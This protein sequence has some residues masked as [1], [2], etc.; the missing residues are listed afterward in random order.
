MRAPAGIPLATRIFLVEAAV[1]LVLGN[2]FTGPPLHDQ[3]YYLSLGASFAEG[4]GIGQPGHPTAFVPPGYPV[5][6]GLFLE[7]FGRHAITAIRVFQLLLLAGTA[8][9]CQD[10]LGRLGFGGR[11]RVLAQLGVAFYPPFVRYATFILTDTI[12]AFLIVGLFWTVVRVLAEPGVPAR[13]RILPWL[14]LAALLAFASVAMRP[15]GMFLTASL[16]LAGAGVALLRPPA[17]RRWALVALAVV[18][19]SLAF[20]TV[21][22]LRN[23]RVL[24]AFVPFSTSGGWVAYSGNFVAG[25]GDFGRADFAKLVGEAEYNRVMGLD[26]IAQN[27]EFT[28]RFLDDLKANPSAM[29]GLWAKKLARYWLNLGYPKPPSRG[30]LFLAAANLVLL[31]LGSWGAWQ[32]WRRPVVPLVKWW[33]LWVALFLVVMTATHVALL[34]VVRY[35]YPALVFVILLAAI[36]ADRLVSRQSRRGA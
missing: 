31:A 13:S 17:R 14:G 21:W 6:V 34:A 24:G 7:F 4:H 19:G 23:Q 32:L 35:A 3:A 29:P 15:T 33:V 18:L 20:V 9:L 12:S 10:M 5:L 30:S 1:L 25:D 8:W 16:V 22:G 28:R 27:R 11:T 36:A 26:E 2:L